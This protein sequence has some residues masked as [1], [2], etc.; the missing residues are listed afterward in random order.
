MATNVNGRLAV[1]FSRKS[2]GDTYISRQLYKL[3]LQILPANYLDQDGTAFL[4]LLNPS[5]GMLEGDN[6]DISFQLKEGARAVISTPSSNKIYKTPTGCARQNIKIKVAAKSVLE[7][8]PDQ[9]V[10]YADSSFGQNTCCQVEK[11][12][13]LFLWDILEPGRITRGEVFSFRSYASETSFFYDGELLL[14]E[15]MCLNTRDIDYLCTGILGE[16]L[17]SASCYLV[18]ENI[19][20]DLVG[21]IGK[22][23]E[24]EKVIAGVSSPHHSIMVIKVL[25]KEIGKMQ[26]VLYRTWNTIRL[27]TQ[28]KEALSFRKY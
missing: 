4:Y 22:Q 10:P 20:T 18:C 6:F 24:E 27:N 17:I 3:P 7:Y 26:D 11:E 13:M 12:G 15:R 9:N 23:L 21:I 1:E 16:Q 14:R 2:T 8:L 28:K 25:T 19:E 5:S